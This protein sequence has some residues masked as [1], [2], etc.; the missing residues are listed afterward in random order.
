VFLFWAIVFQINVRM[1]TPVKINPTT[2]TKKP[3]G[4]TMG[5][6]KRI[7][8]RTTNINPGKIT[9]KTIGGLSWF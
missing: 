5:I 9:C 1:P 7:I 8:P 4:E 3:I 6:P 2:V